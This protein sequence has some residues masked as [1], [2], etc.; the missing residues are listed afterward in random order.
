MAIANL[1]FEALIA[2]GKETEYAASGVID[3]SAALKRLAMAD[4]TRER[5]L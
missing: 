2:D 3:H 5:R 1:P 4:R